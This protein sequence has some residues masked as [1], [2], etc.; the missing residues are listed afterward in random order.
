MP[1]NFYGKI[2][3]YPFSQ[4]ISSNTANYN[5]KSAALSAGW[6]GTTPLAASVTINAGVYVYSAATGAYAFQT[7]VTFPANTTLALTN[8]GTILGCG[9]AGGT[10]YCLGV[11]YVNIAPTAGG[12]GGPAM[13]LQQAITITNNG[14]ISGGGGA[15]G[16]GAAWAT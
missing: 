16:G 6:N 2:Y 1:T 12:A 7:G 5:I 3:R 11:G 15:G 9:G 13:L 14:I 4:T 10:G 8:N